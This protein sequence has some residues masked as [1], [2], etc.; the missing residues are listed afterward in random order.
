MDGSF[1]ATLLETAAVVVLYIAWRSITEGTSL[2]AVYVLAMFMDLAED[3]DNE[4]FY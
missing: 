4:V 3:W 2:V 1:I